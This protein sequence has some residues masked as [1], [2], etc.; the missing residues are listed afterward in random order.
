MTELITQRPADAVVPITYSTRDN[1][2]HHTETL[3]P[4]RLSLM[5]YDAACYVAAQ[6]GVKQLV[7]AG[8]QSYSYDERTTGDL[9]VPHTPE[10]HD[11]EITV[12]RNANNRLLNTPHQVDAISEEFESHE[13]VTV[14]CWAFHEERIKHGFEAQKSGPIVDYVHVED[15]INHL[16]DTEA[17]WED[18][19]QMR[20]DFR[21]RYDIQVD[22]P[23]VAHRGLPPF[24]KREKYT[25]VAMKFGKNGW[26][27]KLLTRAR[28]AGRYDD[29]DEFAMPIQ[30]TTY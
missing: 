24:E 6:T 23:I 21:Q 20:R 12:L 30:R 14:V 25:R 29:I 2:A 18:P 4:S 5:A 8:E 16:W 22:W 28:G 17:L 10:G 27:L 9:L 15:V 3:S 7:I 1:G 13:V 26:L 19:E 11:F